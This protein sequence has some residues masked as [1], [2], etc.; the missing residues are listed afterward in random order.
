M[1]ATVKISAILAALIFAWYLVADR[2]TPYTSNVRVKT[3]VIDIVPEVSGQ[4]AAVAVSNGQV[5]ERGNLLARID[6]RP[7]QL[8]VDRARAALDLATQNVG[9]GSAAIEVA[10]AKLA[11]ERINLENVNV[12]TMRMLELESSGVLSKARADNARATLDGARSA[13]AAAAADLERARR[14]LGDEGTDNPQIR[15][16]VAALG[17]ANLTLEWAELRAPARGI[18]VDLDVTNGVFARAG[19]PLLTFASFEEVWVEAYMKENN[20]ANIDIGDSAEIVLDLYPGRIF[21]GVVASITMG[22]SDGTRDS[23][24]PSAPQVSGWM[25]DPQ[26]FPVRIAMTGYEV[27]SEAHDVR[28][29]M[30]GQADIIVYTGENAFLNALGAAWIRLMSV[31]SYAY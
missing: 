23:G 10:V 20:I 2:I 12:Q 17:E 24:L 16:A 11:A 30:N 19:S 25:R 21:N 15:D 14:E 4:V 7:F 5:V 18:V 13:V 22:A 26:R 6:P 1:K 3:M 8:K 28:R 29:M 31:I 27:G 9:A